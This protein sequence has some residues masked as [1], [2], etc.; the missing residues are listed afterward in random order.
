[1]QNLKIT[2]LQTSL[3]WQQPDTNR[4]AIEARFADVTGKTDLILLPEMFTTGFTMAPEGLAEEEQGE[5]LEWMQRH[6]RLTGAAICGSLIVS[7]PAGFRNRLYWVTPEGESTYYDKVHLFRMANEHE[8]YAAGERRLIIAYRGWRIM[9][10]ICY[11][12]RFPVWARNRNDYDLLLY[13]ANWPAPR[14]HAWRTLLQ[15]RAIENQSYVAGVNRVGRDGNGVD[16]SGDSLLVDFKGELMIDRAEGEVFI[17]TGELD[18][19]A[20]ADFRKAFPAWMDADAF[21]ISGL[22]SQESIDGNR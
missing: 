8:H 14:R 9:P 22:D 4:S 16:Y 15:A 7:S 10:Q 1:M 3:H 13:V 2:L 5:T 17:E 20:L 6:S 19:A 21:S 11:D 12:L 18:G